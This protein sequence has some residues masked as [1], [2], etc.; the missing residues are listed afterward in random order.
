MKLALVRRSFS[1]TGGAELYLQRLLGALRGAGHEVHLFAEHWT[2]A[3]EGVVL[4]EIPVRAPRSMRPRRFA[5]GVRRALQSDQYDCVFSL[6]RTLKQDVYRAGDGVHR[7]WVER[8]R[9]F[10]PWWRR[11]WIG[12]FHRAMMKLEQ[13][14]FDPA[15]TRFVI[16]NSKMVREEIAEHFGFPQEKVILIR[17]GVEVARMR[18]GDR[19]K[20]RN[21]FG[22][23]D[24]DFVC[25]FAGSGWERKGL[26]YVVKAIQRLGGRAKLLVAGK[27]RPF[28]AGE[29]VVFAGPVREMEDLYAAADLFTFTPIYEPSANV[30]FEALAAGLP[31]LTSQYNGASELVTDSTLGA[32]LAD[33]SDVNAIA[34]E[35]EQRMKRPQRVTVPADLVSLDRNVQ[36]TLAVLEMAANTR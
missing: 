31:V 11:L 5:E 30:C 15:N 8:R 17:N 28:P 3:P 13:E 29:N 4:H 9:Q 16:V 7:V 10:G 35:I 32:V 26:H 19:V 21:K 34:A 2:G 24:R 25:L 6:E 22:F 36:E 33:P 18:N 27:G 23:D 1:A 20:T 12:G 14:T